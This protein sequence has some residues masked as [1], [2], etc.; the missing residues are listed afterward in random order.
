MPPEAVVAL[1]Q[2]YSCPSIAFTYSEPNSFYEFGVDTSA[3]AAR[4]GLNAIWV[5]NGYLNPAP[6][7][8]LCRSI[9]AAS[10]NL[11]SFEDRI[12]LD[13]NG[14]H[15]QPVMD[16]LTRIKANGVWLEVIN[17]VIPTYTDDLEM[18]RRMCGWF[19][20]ALGP[21]TPLHFSRFTPLYKL[22]HL[23]P[24]PVDT[25]VRARDIAMSEGLHYVY[26]GNV[27]GLAEDTICPGCKKTV[28]ARKGFRILQNDLNQG[29]CRFC[30]TAISGV[31]SAPV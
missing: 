14:G 12:Y 11:K 29:R 23:A 5:S 17:L 1:A 16:T 21:D 9:K 31:W 2:K 7:D 15:L 20:K 24:T 25:L 8:R 19:L 10:V 27:P 13:L 4:A 3:L 18:I 6:L 30:R 26:I 28:V 22:I